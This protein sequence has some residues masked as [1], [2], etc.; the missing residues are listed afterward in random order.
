MGK[1]EKKFLCIYCY[2]FVIFDRK[3]EMSGIN[4]IIKRFFFFFM[5]DRKR[6][7]GFFGFLFFIG[8]FYLCRDIFNFFVS[9]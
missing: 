9:M 6:M 2:K 3:E 1:G 8:D 4:L 7:I 5:I